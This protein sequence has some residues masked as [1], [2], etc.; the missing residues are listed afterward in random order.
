MVQGLLPRGLVHLLVQVGRET[1]PPPQHSDGHLSASTHGWGAPSCR[2]RLQPRAED[3]ELSVGDVM[4]REIQPFPS[5]QKDTR[6]HLLQL[7]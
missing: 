7:E 6:L 5:Y 1:Q 2:L 4:P 3:K